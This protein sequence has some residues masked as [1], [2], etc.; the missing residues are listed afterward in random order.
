MTSS[1]DITNGDTYTRWVGL[2]GTLKDGSSPAA[3][4][5]GNRVYARNGAN[6]Q[7]FTC[8]TRVRQGPRTV[9]TPW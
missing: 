2:G 1:T 8:Y 5:V 9:G 4:G 7:L 3:A 6:H